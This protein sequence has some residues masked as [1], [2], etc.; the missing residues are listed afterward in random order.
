M[1]FSSV[2]QAVF[3]GWRTSRYPTGTLTYLSFASDIKPIQS[4]FQQ[5]LQ[6][7]SRR[8]YEHVHSC[9]EQLLTIPRGDSVDGD[10]GIGDDTRPPSWE[11][12]LLWNVNNSGV[13]MD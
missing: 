13:T 10:S 7:F 3:R 11:V 4:D 8:G 1:S 9:R 12:A 6:G 2:F 5:I